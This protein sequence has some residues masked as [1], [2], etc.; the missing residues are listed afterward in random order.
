MN[1]FEISEKAKISIPKLRLL[2][3]LGV[4]RHDGS[5]TE[6]D[7]IRETIRLSNKLS[8]AQ[9]VYL[10]ENP[11]GLLELGKYASK[12]KEQLSALDDVAGQVAPREVTALILDAFEKQPEAVEALVAWAKTIIP[13]KP[14]GHSYI[15]T[16]LLLGVPENMRRHEFPR[17]HRALMNCRDVPSF[18]GWHRREK[19]VSRNKTVYQKLALDL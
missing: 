11:A 19:S 3:K 16:R 13:E 17:L 1:I 8:V 5:A 6:L 14:V 7:G 2:D 18:A 15:A 10:I 4:L 12:A 9:L